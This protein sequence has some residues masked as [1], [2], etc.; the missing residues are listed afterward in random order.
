MSSRARCVSTLAILSALL[1]GCDTETDA[2]FCQTDFSRQ[3]IINIDT[4]GSIHLQGGDLG[5]T[6]AGEAARNH[7][8]A[9]LREDSCTLVVLAANS[10]APREAIDQVFAL[11]R[12]NGARNIAIAAGEGP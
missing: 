4:Q 2:S 9:M 5:D 11:L 6:L 8:A 10:E 3:L 7:I 1:S 12:E